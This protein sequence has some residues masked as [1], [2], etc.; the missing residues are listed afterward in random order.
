[1][2]WRSVAKKSKCRLQRVRQ[3]GV[4]L[5]IECMMITFFHSIGIQ[6]IVDACVHM[7]VCMYNTTC[8]SNMY[9]HACV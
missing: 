6:W 3:V 9:V 2:Q 7:H 1:M 4:R 8:M 5:G